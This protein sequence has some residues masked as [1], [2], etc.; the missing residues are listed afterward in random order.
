M[1]QPDK[2]RYIV[3]TPDQQQVDLTKAREIRSNNLYPFGRHNY[4]IYR[5]PEQ[6]FV[7]G[8][9]TASAELMLDTYEIVD[10]ATALN[11]RHPYFREEK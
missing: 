4:A 6:V 8:T 10:E 9:N 7:K 1:N 2:S 5:T 3:T 11:Y